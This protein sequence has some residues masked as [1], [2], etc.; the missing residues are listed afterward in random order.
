MLNFMKQL[1]WWVVKL[2]TQQ[3]IKG[4]YKLPLPANLCK[5]HINTPSTIDRKD[6]VDKI[7]LCKKCQKDEDNDYWK[8]RQQKS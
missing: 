2:H 6:Q 8:S 7:K 4:K 5:I 1:N 3:K